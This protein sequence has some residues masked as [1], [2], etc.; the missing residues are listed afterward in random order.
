M[1]GTSATICCCEGTIPHQ[2]ELHVAHALQKLVGERVMEVLAS[3]TSPQ[4][5]VLTLENISIDDFQPPGPVHEVIKE[6]V[7][8]R[9][10]ADHPITIFCGK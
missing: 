3:I 2:V 7:A 9:Q 10:I 5:F 8:A 4:N 1:G 6:F